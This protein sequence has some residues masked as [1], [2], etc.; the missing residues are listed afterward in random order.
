MRELKITHLYPELLNLYGDKGN[1][2]S[3]KCRAEWRGITTTVVKTAPGDTID[4][5]NTDILFLGGG[6][7]KELKEVLNCLL[8]YKSALSD[9]VEKGGVMLCVCEGFP[10][11]GKSLVIDEEQVEGLGILD[12]ITTASEKRLTGDVLLDCSIDGN[13]FQVAGFENRAEIIDIS[14]EKPLGKVVSGNGETDGAVK[15]N[16]FASNL[17]GPLLPKNPVLCDIILKRALL[18][19][20][21]DAEGF[22]PLDDAFEEEALS[23]MTKR[24]IKE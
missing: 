14:N 22:A 24:L 23:V 9:Y 8:P 10:L 1:I 21:G 4:F 19:K 13:D 18:K 15:N 7:D 16:L 20:Y 3:L 5:E 2:A 11:M 17:H 12:I 6:S